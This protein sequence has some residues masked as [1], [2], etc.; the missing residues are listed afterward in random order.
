MRIVKYNIFFTILY[1]NKFSKPTNYTSTIL[2]YRLFIHQTTKDNYVL[3][4]QYI[5]G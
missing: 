5:S 3:L 4:K 1:S 2:V